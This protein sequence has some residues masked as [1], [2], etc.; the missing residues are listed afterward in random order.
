MM[1]AAHS[2]EGEVPRSRLISSDESRIQAIFPRRVAAGGASPS[3]LPT[4]ADDVFCSN[5]VCTSR[6]T[7][8]TFLPKVLFEQFQQLSNC[9]FLVIG[10][11]QAIPSISPTRGFPSVYV[12]LSFVLF[13]SMLRSAV[14]D[15]RRHVADDNVNKY[16]PVPSLIVRP[17]LP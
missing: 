11:M 5:V 14:E 2:A 3:D 12:P 13:I 8:W 9:Y 17:I 6:Y 10:I 4:E 16:A 1:G 15:Y 7:F